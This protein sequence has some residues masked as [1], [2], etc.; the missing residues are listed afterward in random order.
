[1]KPLSGSELVWWSRSLWRWVHRRN[2]CPRLR[3]A[4][5]FIAAECLSDM[6]CNETNTDTHRQKERQK[7]AKSGP[8]ISKRRDGH[9]LFKRPSI[10][11][12]QYCQ[13][14]KWQG[15]ASECSSPRSRSKDSLPAFPLGTLKFASLYLAAS[16]GMPAN[17]RTSQTPTT[18]PRMTVEL[19]REL[20]HMFT[21]KI[22][23]RDVAR[24]SA[25]IFS[26]FFIKSPAKSSIDLWDKLSQNALSWPPRLEVQG[27]PHNSLEPRPSALRSECST[28]VKRAWENCRPS[29]KL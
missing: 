10:L 1:M 16:P 15:K 2:C 24:R 20:L 13:D 5:N 21:Q 22:P 18:W 4:F 26:I 17:A 29:W 19:V 27:L 25:L 23:Y 14:W 3:E 11:L 7:S 8:H 6:P 28:F 9:S 12:A